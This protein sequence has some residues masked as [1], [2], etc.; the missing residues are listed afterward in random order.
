MPTASKPSGS[1][2]RTRSGARPSERKGRR[3]SARSLDR[4]VRWREWRLAI[5]SFVGYGA[6]MSVVLPPNWPL[7]PFPEPRPVL[8]AGLIGVPFGLVL[9]RRWAPLLPLTLLVAINTPGAGFA[10]SVVVLFLVGP[11]AG[12]GILVGLVSARRL[13]RLALRRVIGRAG[14]P[15][16]A[17]S[18]RRSARSAKAA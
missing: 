16:S 1:S 7:M 12:V 5:V 2:S 11:F 6:L 4:A 17:G 14:R 18:G 10:G 13:Q 15:P 3:P 9:R 8:L